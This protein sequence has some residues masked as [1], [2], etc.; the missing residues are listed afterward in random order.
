MTFWYWRQNESILS[1]LQIWLDAIS[2][3]VCYPVISAFMLLSYTIFSAMELT[4]QWK[5]K[6]KKN[7]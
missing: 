2:V 3:I 4:P 1:F 5:K 7:K 6:N